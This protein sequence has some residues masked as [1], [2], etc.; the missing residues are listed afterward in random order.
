V[1]L[2]RPGQDDDA[3]ADDSAFVVIDAEHCSLRCVHDTG[4]PARGRRRSAADDVAELRRRTST[5][6]CLVSVSWRRDLTFRVEKTGRISRPQ[7]LDQ[8][9]RIIRPLP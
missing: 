1:S 7:E 5:A 6:P 8:R 3:Q 4:C 9:F 2:H